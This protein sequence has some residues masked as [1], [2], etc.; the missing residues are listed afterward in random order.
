MACLQMASSIDI[1]FTIEDK[2][3]THISVIS[4][5]DGDQAI[6]WSTQVP[7]L[8]PYESN[9]AFVLISCTL[10]DNAS[11][12]IPT[13]TTNLKPIESCLSL[14]LR[15]LVGQRF[16]C[17]H[18]YYNKFSRLEYQKLFSHSIVIELLDELLFQIYH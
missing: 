3:S 17:V 8:K 10:R 13:P 16:L 15:S 6:S 1:C 14:N 5:V 4:H 9:S 11:W 18:I 2:F 7:S 12:S